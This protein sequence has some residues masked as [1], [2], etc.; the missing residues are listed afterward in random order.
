[1]PLKQI[2]TQLSAA[3]IKHNHGGLSTNSRC[4]DV[5]MC[6]YA[7]CRIAEKKRK[8]AKKMKPAGVD[9]RTSSPLQ[10]ILSRKEIKDTGKT[11]LQ[12]KETLNAAAKL[13]D[14]EEKDLKYKLSIR[15]YGKDDLRK[16]SHS[17]LLDDTFTGI[18][19]PIGEVTINIRTVSLHQLRPLIEF[20]RTNNMNKRNIIFQEAL[21]L[22]DR[23]PNLY[24]RPRSQLRLYRFGFLKKDKSEFRLVPKE[25]EMKNIAE[26]IGVVDYFDYDLCLVPLSQL[27]PEPDEIEQEETET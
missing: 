5:P 3:D 1:V 10:R 6:Q 26:L 19:S 15:V 17:Y 24:N 18:S 13:S 22:M 4:A 11:N 20:N 2:S 25:D 21:F 8:V 9:K 7:I 16:E 14:A 12:T 27:E 23:L